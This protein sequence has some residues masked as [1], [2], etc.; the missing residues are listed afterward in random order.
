[1]E[2]FFLVLSSLFII[3]FVAYVIYT[4][5]IGAIY[6][7]STDATVEDI[8]TLANI[9]PGEKVVDL[10]SG[11]GRIVIALAR[12]G[13]DA[14]GYE[15]NPFVAVIS[16]VKVFLARQQGRAHIHIGSYFDADLSTYDVI[17]IFV[18]KYIMKKTEAKVMKELKKG[19]RVVVESFPFESIKASKKKNSCYLYKI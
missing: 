18:V 10:G 17:T 16:M 12:A 11:D 19:G 3:F 5:K 6:V 2:L 9:K 1:M 15:I 4:I 13:A 14:H 8:I 7:P